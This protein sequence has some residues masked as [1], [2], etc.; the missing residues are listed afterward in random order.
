MGGL[1]VSE[2]VSFKWEVSEKECVQNRRE[3]S[4]AWRIREK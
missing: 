2:E 1:E 4:V 3:Y